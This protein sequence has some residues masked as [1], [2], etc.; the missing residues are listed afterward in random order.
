MTRSHEHQVFEEMGEAGAAGLLARRPDV[1]PDVHRQQRDGVILVQD[2]LQ[3]V[4]QCELRERHIELPSVPSWR[5][6][7]LTVKG[8]AWPPG[9]RP[10][11]SSTSL[12]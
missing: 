10:K 5:S 11:R 12:S 7:L 4:G 8:E 6:R 1:I 3:P 2:D 9:R